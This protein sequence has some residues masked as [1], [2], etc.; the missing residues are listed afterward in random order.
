MP[1]EDSF[2]AVFNIYSIFG[3]VPFQ[4][5]FR[6]ISTKSHRKHRFCF[7][8]V[9]KLW[10]TCL[11]LFE[12]FNSFHSLI[13]Y[14]RDCLKCNCMNS[15]NG[16]RLIMIFVIRLCVIVITVESYCR[17]ITHVK[18][19][20][21]LHEIDRMFT[22]KL[23]MQINYH[24]L[25]RSVVAASLKWMFVF[26][27]VVSIFIANNLIANKTK[28]NYTSLLLAV[29]SF[30]KKALFGCTYITCAILIRHRVQAMHQVL[31]SILIALNE[32]AIDILIDRDDGQKDREIFEFR[33]LVHL[34]RLFP[35][36]HETV[37]LMNDSFKW[38]ISIAFFANLFDIS[39]K[40]FYNLDEIFGSPEKCRSTIDLTYFTIASIFYYVFAFGTIIQTANSVA[41]EAEKI[42]PKIQQII[43][44]GTN[45]DELQ[46]FVSEMG[47]RSTIKAPDKLLFKELILCLQLQLF[48]LQQK[49]QPIH[50]TMFGF[51]KF[52]YKIVVVV[53]NHGIEWTNKHTFGV[54]WT[55]FYFLRLIF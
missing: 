50:L 22:H 32:S 13:F 14:Y 35:R 42:A 11:I 31:D 19:Q 30:L 52:H 51:I 44:C 37:Q 55:V 8:F 2:T 9:E 17:R 54:R 53:S 21:N 48:S 26:V 3:L 43:S 49:H 25:K 20:Q 15:F 40:I 29:Y 41:K 47:S 45:S 1:F 4:F 24:R 28:L 27:V 23:K 36:L 46:L 5:H 39:A 7:L 16:F 6:S 38:S 34:W 12:L 33:R 18:I 10:F